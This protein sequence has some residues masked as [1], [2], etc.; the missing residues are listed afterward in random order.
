M[1][2]ETWR[3]SSDRDSTL[4]FLMMQNET[5]R[6]QLCYTIEDAWQPYKK[7]GRTRIP[8]G[9]YKIEFRS[10]SPMA[11]RYASQFSDHMG[12]LWL[13]DVPGFEYVYL[14][15]GNDEDDTE[16]CLLLGLHVNEVARTAQQ[17]RAAYREVYP[18][19]ALWVDDPEGLWITIVDLDR[20]VFPNV[21]Q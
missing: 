16:G 21:A 2:I 1:E 8:P 9:R 3:Y 6:E 11:R 10:D 4:G 5:T 17:S 12:M 19:L 14:H 20:P 7:P 13:Q 18:R 15:I